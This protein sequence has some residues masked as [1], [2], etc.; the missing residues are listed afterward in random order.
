MRIGNGGVAYTMTGKAARVNFP[1]EGEL[2]VHDG[3][4]CRDLTG[5]GLRLESGQGRRGRAGYVFKMMLRH[6]PSSM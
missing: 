2:S 6:F 1:C 5:L 3:W 4:V